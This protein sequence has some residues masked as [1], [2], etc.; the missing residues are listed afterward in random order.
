M[1][2]FWIVP[3]WADSWELVKAH[4]VYAFAREVLSG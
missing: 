4:N 3:T 1:V 2:V